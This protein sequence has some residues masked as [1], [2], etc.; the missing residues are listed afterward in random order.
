MQYVLEVMSFA[1]VVPGARHF[2]GRVK[3]E[4]PPSCHGGTMYSNLGK[5]CMQGHPLAER[6]EWQVEA[7]WTEERYERWAAK[8][9]EGDGPSQFLSKKDVIDRAMIV[10]LDGT[11]PAHWWAQKVEPAKDGDELWYGYIHPEGFPYDES[12]DYSDGWGSMIARCS[13]G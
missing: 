7:G 8:H 11:D 9:F 12:E 1:G 2:K 4:H 3:G 10:F 6:T 13:R 5:T